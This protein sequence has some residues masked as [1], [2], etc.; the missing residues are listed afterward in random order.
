MAQNII[1]VGGKRYR[2]L[3]GKKVVVIKIITDGTSGDGEGTFEAPAHLL[4]DTITMHSTDSEGL[5][6]FRIGWTTDS[7]RNEDF[8]GA[9]KDDDPEYPIAST[10]FTDAAITKLD[11]WNLVFSKAK[12]RKFLVYNEGSTAPYT[13]RIVLACRLLEEV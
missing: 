3:P 9:S 13:V 8:F 4:V 12:T 5:A 11:R 1:E 6:G 10:L 2:I 7:G